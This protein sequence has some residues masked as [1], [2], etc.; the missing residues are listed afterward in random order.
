[1]NDNRKNAYRY[2]LYYF[3]LT[4]RT[5]PVATQP[6]WNQQ[7]LLSHSYYAGS[8]AYLLH[9][10]ALAAATD[11]EHFDENAFWSSL[12]QFSINNPAINL[13]DYP[14]V[15]TTRLAELDR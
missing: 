12:S 1:M 4:I 15:C 3:L 7:Q 14:T 6:V 9:T 11:F 2:L 13:G 10:L 8:V 5:T